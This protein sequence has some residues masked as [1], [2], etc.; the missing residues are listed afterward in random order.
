MVRTWFTS[1]KVLRDCLEEVLH[2]LIVWYR[3]VRLAIT[4]NILW[5]GTI[6]TVSNL[7]VL[8]DFRSRRT[9][10]DIDSIVI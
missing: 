7:F 2:Y 3:I 4:V 9:A 8:V 5:Y 6:F 1:G 10:L